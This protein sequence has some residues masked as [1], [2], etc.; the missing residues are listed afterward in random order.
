MSNFVSYKLMARTSYCTFDEMMMMV[1]T[2]Y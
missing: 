2:L 1:A